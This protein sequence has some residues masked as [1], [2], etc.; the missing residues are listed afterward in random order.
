[1][2]VADED[3][4]IAPERVSHANQSQTELTPQQRLVALWARVRQDS[5]RL[6][7]PLS[8]EDQQ[9]Q[10][11]PDV[12]PTKWHLA[13]TTWFFEQF[14]LQPLVPTYQVY[15]ADYCYLFN[16]YY[17]AVG[18]RHPRPQRG[19][20]TRP[21]LEQIHRYRDHVDG[22]LAAVLGS[23]NVDAEIYRRLVLG[24]NHEQQHQELLLSDIQHVLSINPLAPIYR[25]D[26][27]G[28]ER[29]DGESTWLRVDRDQGEIGHHGAEFA[30]DNEGPRH[31]VLATPFELA[32]ALVSEREW[33]AFI[34]DGGYQQAQWWMADGWARVQS[35]AWVA[36]QYWRQRDGD[37]V[38]F[39]LNGEQPIDRHRPVSHISWY[40]ADA[41]ARWADARLPTEHEW[42]LAASDAV[43]GS[44]LQQ[45][46]TA[47]WQWTASAY[48]AYPKFK[49][50]PGALGEYNGKFM[51]NQF[52][53]RGGAHATPHGH[54]RVTYR[55]FYYPHQRWQFA[56]LR[57]ARDASD[58]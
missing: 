17:E 25:S 58:V 12:S 34:E 44:Q 26:W 33:L 39:G 49:P 22:A 36:P 57:L 11:M 43:I 54:S 37:W 45:L 50:S 32:S 1:M 6:T 19:L 55:N 40:E 53:L 41:Y 42:E 27:P 51:C 20:L 56:G 28:P 38:V 7:E 16:S 47:L 3:P 52:V 23:G 29:K 5:M 10:S 24:L 48:A 46:R 30:F 21:S 14:I 31:R 4:V 35:D 2:S 9:V 8:A 15:D 13:H 18:S